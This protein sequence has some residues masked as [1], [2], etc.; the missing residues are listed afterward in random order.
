MSEL[1]SLTKTQLLRDGEPC[2]YPGCLSHVSHPCEGCGRIG[3]MIAPTVIY[4]QRREAASQRM[5]ARVMHENRVR[6]ECLKVATEALV[7]YD[8]DITNCRI[9]YDAMTK[10]EQ[11]LMELEPEEETE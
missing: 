10:I 1:T 7:W 9:A 8:N 2:D 11:R 6:D 4:W 5:L 3:G